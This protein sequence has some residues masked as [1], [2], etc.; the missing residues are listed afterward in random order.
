M[1]C[2]WNLERAEVSNQ[3]A[4]L[5][6][7]HRAHCG[8]TVI[9]IP[10]PSTVPISAFRKRKRKDQLIFFLSS[11][12]PSMQ[13]PLSGRKRKVSSSLGCF[14]YDACLWCSCSSLDGER[15][16]DKR[17]GRT[18]KSCL[19]A[20][21]SQMLGRLL[22]CFWRWPWGTSVESSEGDWRYKRFPWSAFP[23]SSHWRKILRS[24]QAQICSSGPAWNSK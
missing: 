2:S 24:G 18:D 9:L 20:F 16:S 10:L 3:S 14:V 22:S 19:L 17:A 12:P 21:L 5:S 8:S 23:W 13:H 11:A 15:I 1:S 7:V 6:S 4:S